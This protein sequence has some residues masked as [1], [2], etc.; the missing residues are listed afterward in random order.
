MHTT[1]KPYTAP[2]LRSFAL[3]SEG[4]LAGSSTIEVT[5]EN[6]DTSEK[7]SAFDFSDDW[8]DADSD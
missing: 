7:S 8:A 5:E 6:V 4:P 1:R 2:R 3:Q